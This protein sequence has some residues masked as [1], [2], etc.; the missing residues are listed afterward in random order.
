MVNGY[1][2]QVLRL[3]LGGKVL[4]AAGKS[5]KGVGEFGEAHSV[6]VS[7][8]GDIWVADPSNGVVQKFVRK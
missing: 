6:A 7:A 3:D 5:G 2:G 1:G 4:A 8:S